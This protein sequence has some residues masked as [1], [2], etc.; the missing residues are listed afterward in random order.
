MSNA[1]QQERAKAMIREFVDQGFM[2]NHMRGPLYAVADGTEAEGTAE[3]VLNIC[4]EALD[5]YASR[6]RN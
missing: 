3:G 4:Q 2:P 6:R 1:T 5:E